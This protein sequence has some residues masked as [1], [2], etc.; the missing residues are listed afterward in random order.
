MYGVVLSSAF[1][2][3]AVSFVILQQFVVF[4]QSTAIRSSYSW[5]L[6]EGNEDTF[7]SQAAT[8]IN[9]KIKTK[10]TITL[11][12]SQKPILK[13][14]DFKKF[15]IFFGN[16]LYLWSVVW[17]EEYSNLHAT[18]PPMTSKIP[19][20]ENIIPFTKLHNDANINRT[21]QILWKIS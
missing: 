9:S 1:T 2:S 13:I 18:N 21:I 15:E 7:L 17:V 8:W 19:K 6:P 10:T 12:S 4:S 5:P 11:E 16:C 14:F 20:R 3:L